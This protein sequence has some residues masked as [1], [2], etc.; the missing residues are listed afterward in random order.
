MSDYIDRQ[1]AIDA[2]LKAKDKGELHR[3]LIQLPSVQLNLQS[4]CNQLATDCISRQAAIELCDWY[5]HDFI[6]VEAYFK[7]FNDELRK[8]PSAQ[9]E[10]QC[11]TCSYNCLSWDEEPCDSCTI[12]NS[13]YKP[14][15][16]PER[17]NGK[18]IGKHERKLFSHPDSITYECSECGYSIYTIY[19][20]PETTN[21]CPNC[22]ADMRG[23]TE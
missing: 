16:H 9:P 5:E 12:A 22:G 18:W 10:R 14:S 13:H 17:K 23:D 6:E 15:A 2:L 11:N 20:M 1:A 7:Q 19:G 8:L 21:F 3:L 4:T